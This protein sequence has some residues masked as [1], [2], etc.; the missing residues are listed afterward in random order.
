M[1]S[2]HP[3]YTGKKEPKNVCPECLV[4]RLKY[5]ELHSRHTFFKPTQVV[6]SKKEYQRHPKHKKPYDDE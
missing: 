4:V 2:K 5:M 1:C 6:P 3:K